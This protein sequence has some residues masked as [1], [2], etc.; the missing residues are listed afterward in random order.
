MLQ[1]RTRKRAVAIPSSTVA[2]WQHHNGGV[3]CNQTCDSRD[4]AF[5]L[6]PHLSLQARGTTT[7]LSSGRYFLDE[8]DERRVVTH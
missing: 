6:E 5:G 3:R 4:E 2:V 1:S 7:S 8:R